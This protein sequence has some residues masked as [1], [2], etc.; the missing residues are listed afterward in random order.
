[1]RN[2]QHVIFLYYWQIFKSALAY[3]YKL[4]Q[5]APQII[6]YY[7]MTK[8]FL[9][10]LNLRMFWKN[11]DCFRF[12]W[13]TYTKLYANN[14][15]ISRVGRPSLTSL[16][17]WSVSGGRKLGNLGNVRNLGNFFPAFSLPTFR[18]WHHTQNRKLGRRKLGKQIPK[19]PTFTTFLSFRFTTFRFNFQFR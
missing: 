1:M 8:E 15:V 10:C 16:C 3:L 6:L 17:D 4:T 14:N 11:I 18:F 13:K 9:N 2:Q 12:W 7:H 5:N 19:F